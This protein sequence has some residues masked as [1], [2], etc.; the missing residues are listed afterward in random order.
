ME[1]R[2]IKTSDTKQFVEFYKKLAKETEF[3]MFSPDEVSQ[4]ESQ[5]EHFIKSYDDFKHV[6]LAVDKNKIVGYLGIARSHLKKLKHSAKFTVGV[7]DDHKRQGIATQLIEYAENWA[8]EQGIKRL[9]L[10]VIT[11]N[12]PAVAFFKKNDFDQEG[13]RKK[14][15][16]LDDEYFDEYF[17][18]KAL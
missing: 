11:G 12:K 5:E 7:L 2:S 13:T 8:K 6:F 15:V 3:L 9:E 18:A 16:N 1:I 4:K 14:S 10:T 17:M